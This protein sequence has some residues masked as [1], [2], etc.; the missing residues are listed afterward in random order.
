MRNHMSVRRRIVAAVLAIFAS[1]AAG[2]ADHVWWEAERPA[3][4]NFPA[5]THFMAANYGDKRDLLSGGDWLSSSG[6]RG[7]EE[8]FARWNVEVDEAGEYHFWTRK[9]YTHGPFRWRF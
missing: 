7:A 8:A 4:T 6:K 2:A 1:A 5:R 3:A 9:F